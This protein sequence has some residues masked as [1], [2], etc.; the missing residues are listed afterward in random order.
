MNNEN[1]NC[2]ATALPD[3]RGPERGADAQPKLRRASTGK[4]LGNQT[5]AQNQDQ[6]ND[7]GKFNTSN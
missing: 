7:T 5:D 4:T 2:A 1:K 6:F 3:P